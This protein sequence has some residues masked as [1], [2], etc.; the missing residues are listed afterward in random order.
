MPSYKLSYFDGRGRAEIAR[1][2]FAAKGVE[3]TDERLAGEKWMEFKP[4]TPYGQL[5]VL[6]VDEQQI[7]QSC[8][9][10]RYL[11]RTFGY[12]GSNNNENTAVDMIVET[13]NDVL[14]DVIKAH[15]EKDEKEK[16][17]QQ[18]KMG[19]ETFP[20]FFTYLENILKKNGTGYLV[21]KDLTLADINV[22]DLVSTIT[23]TPETKDICKGYP[24]L[25]ALIK[26]VSENKGIAAWLEKRPKT[27]F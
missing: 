23:G 15:F 22:F 18:K 10:F 17:A 8:A 27:T 4:K 6:T 3:Y 9:I 19:E 26:K 21:G 1:L 24:L 20:K 14:K 12:Y 5:P 13:C 2:M 11:A 7:H 25:T 16:A